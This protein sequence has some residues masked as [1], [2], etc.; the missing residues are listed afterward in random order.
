MFTGVIFDM[1]GVL[2]NSEQFYFDRRMQFFREKNLHPGSTDI[3]DYLGMSNEQVWSALV[4]DDER[5]QQLHKEY[6]PYQASHP[7]DYARFMFPGVKPLLRYLKGHHV[8]VGLASAG[9]YGDIYRMLDECQITQYFTEVLSGEEVPH[10]KPEPD[11]YLRMVEL[12]SIPAANCLVIEDSTNG[13]AAAKA[14][15]LTTWAIDQSEYGVDQ[16]RA[17]RIVGSLDEVRKSLK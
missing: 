17:D 9:I 15:G 6:L 12:L 8:A 16:S 3:R 13:I 7:I 4:P 5:R 14:A 10:N 1:D 11:I 2:V